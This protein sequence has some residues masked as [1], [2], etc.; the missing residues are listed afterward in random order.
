MTNTVNGGTGV[1]I[2]PLVY[3][4]AWYT[5]SIS[6]RMSRTQS[7]V[8]QIVLTLEAVHIYTRTYT[9]SMGV[10]SSKKTL[11]DPW[12]GSPFQWLPCCQIVVCGFREYGYFRDPTLP[13]FLYGPFLDTD[14]S[15][16]S[17]MPL[18]VCGWCHGTDNCGINLSRCMITT[19]D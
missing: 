18:A 5:T 15:T 4:T 10:E 16:D 2:N 6:Q 12:L 1:P 17:E 11:A 8:S 9:A 14:S 19:T 7:A 3:G 13:P